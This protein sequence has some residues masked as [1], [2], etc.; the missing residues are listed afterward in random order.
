MDHPG[1]FNTMRTTNAE[2]RDMEKIHYGR[3]NDLRRAAE[4]HRQVRKL[5]QTYMR[6]GIKLID[7]CEKIEST[8]R[9]LVEANGIA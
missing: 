4:C 5:A 2:Y 7:I 8:N 9:R 6:P 3:V 1:D